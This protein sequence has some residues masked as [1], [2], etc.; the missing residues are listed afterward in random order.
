MS[1]P[2]QPIAPAWE[3]EYRANR[4]SKCMVF[5]YVFGYLTEAEKEKVKKRIAKDFVDPQTIID[6][7]NQ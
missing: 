6:A 2:V 3:A 7:G 5:L 4:A 1:D